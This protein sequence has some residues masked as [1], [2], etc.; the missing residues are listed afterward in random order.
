MRN[1]KDVAEIKRREAT[2]S[3]ETAPNYDQREVLPLAPSIWASYVFD[4]LNKFLKD[5]PI[6]DLGCGTGRVS[7]YYSDQGYQVVG[8]DISKEMLKICRQKSAGISVCLGDGARLPFRD[9]SFS[10]VISYGALHHIPDIEAVFHELHRVLVP[11]GVLIIDEPLQAA[12]PKA[13]RSVL[14]KFRNFL[15]HL[16][17]P[18]RESVASESEYDL[19]FNA[20]SK[21]ASK[22]DLRTD[23]VKFSQ[24]GTLS[25]FCPNR[26]KIL[27]ILLWMDGLVNR[28]FSIQIGSVNMVFHTLT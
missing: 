24:Y 16:A 14:S 4:F 8:L 3:D 15:L 6:L 11:G 23:L 10:T 5:G 28:I 19:D 26:K 12:L 7:K 20:V 13:V 1:H 9:N 17:Q 18:K 22:V 21:I 2:F 25:N 27:Q